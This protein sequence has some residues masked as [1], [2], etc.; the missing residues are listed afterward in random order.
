MA[1]QLAA[2]ASPA[3][4]APREARPLAVAGA[5]LAVE[6]P[7]P[8]AVAAPVAERELALA[9]TVALALAITQLAAAGAARAPATLLGK[10]RAA[11]L[12]EVVAVVT[13]E[14]AIMMVRRVARCL[15]ERERCSLQPLP[16]FS[17]L[18]KH[19]RLAQ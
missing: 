9:A 13:D 1:A 8:A 15:V 17:P 6:V 3:L 18:L 19:D 10:A 2:A 12:A 14:E 16:Q 5:A 7:A 4:R 11:V